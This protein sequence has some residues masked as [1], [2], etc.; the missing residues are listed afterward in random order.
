MEIQTIEEKRTVTNF[1]DGDFKLKL[2]D[3]MGMCSRLFAGAVIVIH[4][5]ETYN[6]CTEKNLIKTIGGMDKEWECK[7]GEQLDEFF[8]TLVM[9]CKDLK[10]EDM[11]Y[12]Q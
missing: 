11:K 7:K 5:K 12:A 2:S 10:L 4:D 3:M 6:Y 8:I 9:T 1:C